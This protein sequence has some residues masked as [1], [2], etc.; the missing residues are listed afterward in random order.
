MDAAPI[1]LLL[2][3]ALQ[4]GWAPDQY[5]SSPPAAA[6][7]R[8]RY[9]P[10]PD[11]IDRTRT[12][13]TE[14]GSTLREGVEAGIQAT[15]QHLRGWTDEAGRQLQSGGNNVRA[16]ADRTLGAASSQLQQI[17]NPFGATS[18]P[19]ATTSRTRGSVTPPP[20]DESLEGEETE[21]AWDTEP[22]IGSSSVDYTSSPG[23]IPTRSASGWTS[24]GTDV[25]A[26]PLIVPRLVTTTVNASSHSVT[27]APLRAVAG[28]GGPN[29]PTISTGRETIHGALDAR[30]RQP[31]ASAGGTSDWATG[32]G[33][34]APAPATIGRAGSIAPLDNT[35]RS[36]ELARVQPANPRQET[37]QNSPQAGG[38]GDLWAD[39]NRWIQPPQATPPAAP[40]QPFVE[41]RAN[42]VSAGSG[43][44]SSAP[45]EP[46]A[47]TPIAVVPEAQ[48]PVA[49]MP[50]GI[51]ASASAP[52]VVLPADTGANMST[53]P[54]PAATAEQRPWLPLLLVSLSLAGSLGGNLFLGW[55]YLE[56]RQKYRSLVRKTAD[57][58]CRAAA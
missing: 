45:S 18:A 28:D 1:L 27:P 49:I 43:N 36:K 25:A 52:A 48:P 37:A 46:V 12:A 29:F 20:W 34:T 11:V 54:A 57:K 4:V 30:S 5:P 53:L 58:F 15:G 10:P 39:D 50:N 31:A 44:T 17:T 51:N 47:S 40:T 41:P 14:S 7:I 2:A 23:M 26:P 19:P 22:A 8:D 9:A 6:P 35:I 55:S 16:A 24:I 42:I 33:D 38:W 3:V 56:A 13:I 32:W 21:P